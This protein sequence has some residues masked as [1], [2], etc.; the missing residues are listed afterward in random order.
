[1]KKVLITVVIILGVLTCICDKTYAYKVTENTHSNTNSVTKVRAENP[2]ERIGTM[3]ALGGSIGAISATIFCLI[4]IGKH[5][6][7]KIANS[8]GIYLDE[9]NVEIT[10]SEDVFV[11]SE[12]KKIRRN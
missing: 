12:I 7:V 8:A 3:T 5:K 9:N 11:R 10:R 2:M 1:M 6:Q 4:N